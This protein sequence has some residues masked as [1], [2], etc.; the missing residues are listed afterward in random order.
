MSKNFELLQRLEREGLVSPPAI[1]R[2][3]LRA[4]A[5]STPNLSPRIFESLSKLVQRLFLSKSSS[6]RQ[7]VFAGAEPGVGTSWITAQTTRVLACQ[8]ASPICLVNASGSTTLL[9]IFD[10]PSTTQVSDVPLQSGEGNIWLATLAT[11]GQNAPL[12][13]EET[14]RRMLEL[15][16]EF[17]F[18]LFDAPPA[19]DATDAIGLGV[20]S[21]GIVLVVKAGSTRR[22]TVQ[23]VKADLERE[24][25]KLLGTVLNQS[26]YPIPERIYKHL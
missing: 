25:V 13:R 14:A 15:R 8:N 19:R 22:P 18:V 10:L 3:P 2:E 4:P 20:L 1:Q 11:A 24:H 23:Q 16:R 5:S 7:V 6:V 9:G 12:T 26:E 17:Q 21:D